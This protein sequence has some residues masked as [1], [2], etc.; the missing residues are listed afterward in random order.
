MMVNH[1]ENLY[2]YVTFLNSNNEEAAAI[3]AKDVLIGVTNFLP[4]SRN[5]S[6]R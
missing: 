6:M 4:R 3:L 1:I 5:A 2:D